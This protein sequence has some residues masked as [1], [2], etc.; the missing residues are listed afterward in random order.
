MALFDNGSATRTRA[1]RQH[2][3][4]DKCNQGFWTTSIIWSASMWARRSNKE[5]LMKFGFL[6]FPGAGSGNPVWLER[7]RFGSMDHRL[8]ILVLA[9][10]LLWASTTRGMWVAC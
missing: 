9:P 8:T 4:H 6:G 10:S 5:R 7:K 2:G 1:I 3:K